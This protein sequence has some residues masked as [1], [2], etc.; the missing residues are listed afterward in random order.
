M[1]KLKYRPICDGWNNDLRSIGT[2]DF[3]HSVDKVYQVIFYS[4]WANRTSGQ[5]FLCGKHLAEAKKNTMY[6]I[7]VDGEYEYGGKDD[8]ETM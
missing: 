8:R 7:T 2:K 1:I 3:Y 5:M 6:K 4:K